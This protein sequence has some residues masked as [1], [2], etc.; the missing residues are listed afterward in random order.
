[1][2][3]TAKDLSK[4]LRDPE[5]E[6]R[7]DI[8]IALTHARVPNVC[9]DGCPHVALLTSFVNSGH[10]SREGSLRPHTISTEGTTN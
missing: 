3:D 5:G 2:A 6:H 9:V 1:M 7:V 4:R 8:I 10:R